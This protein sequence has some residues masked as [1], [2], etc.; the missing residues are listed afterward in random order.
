MAPRLNT[1]VVLVLVVLV[2]C[3]GSAP[4]AAAAPEAEAQTGAAAPVA[5]SAAQAH[6]PVTL[7]IPPGAEAGP[8]FDVERAT[9]AYLGLLT[10]EQRE[11]SDSYFEGGYVLLVVDLLYGLAMAWLLLRTRLSARMRNWADRVTTNPFL[12]GVLYAVQYLVVATVLAFPLTLYAG[13]F[14][15]HAYGLATQTLGAWLGD[16]LKK[17]VIAVIFGGLGL[18]VLYAVI[19]RFPR[20]WWLGGAI[21]GVAMLML[22]VLIA[23]VWLAPLF[24]DYQPLEPGPVRESIL[25]MARG[26]GVPSDNVYWFDASRQTTRISANVSGLFGT[27]RISLNDNLLR[28]TAPEEIEAVMGHEMGHYLLGHVWATLISIGLL[29]VVGLAVSRWAF[30]RLIERYGQRWDVRG[31][32]DPAGLPL[33][34]AIMSV[35]FFAITPVTNSMIRTNES[36]ADIFGLNV[37]R[38]PDGFARV[39]I[40]LSDYRKL[41]PG[42]LEEIFFY[43]HPSGRARVE[44]SMRWK[45]EQLRAAAR[46]AAARA[47]QGGATPGGGAA[48]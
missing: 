31:Q 10:P 1:L 44:M 24:N 23:P 13:F 43:D 46:A 39:A 5:G 25:S 8:D 28:R 48:E 30:L 47:A 20:T 16:E 37:A 4:A 38:Q 41:D 33:L 22:S 18:G 14:R 35:Y 36:Q 2:P 45:A 26:N 27:T 32:S 7:E 9:Q 42:P 6:P 3:L 17:L 19:R 29:L 34:L 11:R 15:E 40:R 12:R 21:A